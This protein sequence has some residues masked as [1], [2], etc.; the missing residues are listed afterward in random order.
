MARRLESG[1]HLLETAIGPLGIAWRHRGIDR[2]Q[3]PHPDLATTREHLVRAV[4]GRPEPRRLPTVARSWVRRIQRHLAGKPDPLRDIPLD[5]EGISTFTRRVYLALRQV[6]P[7]QV[8]TYARLARRAGS[9]GGARAV[10]RA[11]ATN[12]LPLLVPCHRVLAATGKLGGFTAPGGIAL[13]ERILFAEGLI[14]DSRYAEGIAALRRADPRLRRIINAVGPYRAIPREGRRGREPVASYEILLESIIHQQL[15]L[16]AAATIAARV[17]RLTPGPGFPSP[18]QVLRMKVSRLRA[19][20]LSAQKVSYVKDLAARVETGNLSLGR[21]RH[22]G[23]EDIVRS[24]C[25]V[26]GLGRWSAEMFLIF[27]LDRLDVLP[28][29]DLGFRKGVQKA[30]RLTEPPQADQIS[31]LAERWR[32]YRSMATWYFWQSL[33]AGGI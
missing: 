6:P 2:V 32:P 26:H 12:P 28:V 10:G 31:R 23:D 30:Y 33:R 4:P 16:K 1:I 14:L 3:L 24:L 13:K 29:G 21:L 20:G 8:V 27:H 7:G 5:L 25:E 17:R 22:M 11:M 9:P 15:S 19:A 18:R